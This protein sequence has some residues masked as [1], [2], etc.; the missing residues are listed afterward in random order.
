MN[1]LNQQFQ[2]VKAN[3]D[4]KAYAERHLEKAKQGH[5]FVCP[6]CN[7]GGNGG[8]NSDSGFSL[9]RDSFKCF[10]CQAHGDIFD[11]A[12]KCERI[13]TNNKIEQLKAVASFAGIRLDLEKNTF[14]P[15]GKQSNTKTAKDTAQQVDYTKGREKHE[16]YI[17]QCQQTIKDTSK[18]KGAVTYL[19]SRGFDL[20]TAVNLG[21]GYDEVTR[22]VIIP[23]KGSKYYHFDRAISK[24]AKIKHYKP[25]KDEVGHQ[26]IY[27]SDALKEKTV[28]IVEGEFDALTLHSL[29]FDNVIMTGG[30]IAGINELVNLAKQQAEKPTFLLLFD[31]DKEGVNFSNS[32]KELLDK[33]K[34]PCE[35]LE[36]SSFT[37]KDPNEMFLSNRDG[38]KSFLKA[39]NE[40]ALQKHTDDINK[41]YNKVIA[42]Y[43]ML[44]IKDV[45]WQIYNMQCYNEPVST[46]FQGID[47]SL[48]GGFHPKNLI[49]LGAG[50]SIGKTSLILQMAANIA[51]T[52]PVLFVSIEQSQ[53][54]LQAKLISSYSRR[55]SNYK[56]Y[57]LP[58]YQILNLRKYAYNDLQKMNFLQYAISNF[59][60]DVKDNLYL[61]ECVNRPSVAEIETI[62]TNIQQ[63]ENKAPVIFVDYLQ[64]LA[65]QSERDTERQVTDKNLTSLKQLANKLITPV[66][67][68][69]SLNRESYVKQ[70][71]LNSFKESGCIEYSADVLLGLQPQKLADDIEQAKTE[72]AEKKQARQSIEAYKEEK[73]GHL[74]LRVL[75]HRNGCTNFTGKELYFDKA[76]NFFYEA[77]E[78]DTKKAETYKQENIY[79]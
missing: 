66:I 70:V 32:T 59:E 58:Y 77:I 8:R 40:K 11:L 25:K 17:L 68:I 50:S 31:K 74:V 26:P 7:S 75:K 61:L 78:T 4:I 69:S 56:E 34:I 36:D 2:N 47:Y 52:R 41:A 27:N 76:F 19:A 21:V 15:T 20:Q 37:G 28:F 79:F 35:M 1:N 73:I 72:V 60:E 67:V 18:N 16:A 53:Q 12:S 5:M 3:A 23:C 14:T 9:T 48:N 10:A 13:D 33:N 71:D 63:H 22:R 24:E 55:I 29:G 65:A 38:F 62:A 64:L 43:S 6:F 45:N 49:I 46:G 51:R 54:E 39:E 57:G 42:N 44:P 30:G